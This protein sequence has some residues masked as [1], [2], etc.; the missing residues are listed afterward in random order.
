MLEVRCQDKAVVMC[1]ANS[2]CF[3]ENSSLTTVIPQHGK[4]KTARV[5]VHCV[6]FYSL[7]IVCYNA[8]TVSF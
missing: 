8:V 2:M 7:V 1:Q 4:I 3:Y 6:Q 5:S